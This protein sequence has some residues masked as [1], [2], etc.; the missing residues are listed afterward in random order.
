MQIIKIAEQAGLPLRNLLQFGG[1]PVGAPRG[2][3]AVKFRHPDH[4]MLFWTGRGIQPKWVSIWLAESGHT[5][6]M[7]RVSE[8]NSE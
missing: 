5:L 8:P 1:K 7:L 3:V 4:P 2:K 6:A